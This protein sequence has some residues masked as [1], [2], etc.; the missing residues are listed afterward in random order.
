MSVGPLTDVAIIIWAAI[1]AVAASFPF[2]FLLG[3]TFLTYIKETTLEKFRITKKLKSLVGEKKGAEV[4]YE[5]EI[6][7]KE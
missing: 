5:R 4:E 6:D 7:E 2:P 1:A 3:G